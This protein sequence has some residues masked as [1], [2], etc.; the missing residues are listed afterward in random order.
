MTGIGGITGICGN[1]GMCGIALPLY[2][3]KGGIS[4]MNGISEKIQRNVYLN[5]ELTDL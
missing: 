2:S 4:G 1:T 3:K 5:G